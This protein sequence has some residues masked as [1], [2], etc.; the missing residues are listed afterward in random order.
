VAVTLL[1]DAV[2]KIQVVAPKV[3][4]PTRRRL[5]LRSDE[6]RWATLTAAPASNQ[7][8]PAVELNLLGPF[9]R[10]NSKNAGQIGQF[11]CA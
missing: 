3:R 8:E 4:K 5:S 10:V 11:G 2:G 9:R 6:K 1:P 7:R